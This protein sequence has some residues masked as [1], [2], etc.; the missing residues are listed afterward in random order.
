MQK[1]PAQHDKEGQAKMEFSGK[2]G[3]QRDHKNNL[4]WNVEKKDRKCNKKPKINFC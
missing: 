4:F 2:L 1:E 3:K